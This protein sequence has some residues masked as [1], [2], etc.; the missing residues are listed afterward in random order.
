MCNTAVGGD[1]IL[2]EQ[3]EQATSSCE[4]KG[5][6]SIKI[7]EAQKLKRRIE[8]VLKLIHCKSI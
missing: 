5:F 6:K 7:T 2:V 4:I 3:V 1:I 8:D